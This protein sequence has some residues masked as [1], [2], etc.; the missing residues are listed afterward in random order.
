[1]H[2][3]L[4]LNNIPLIKKCIKDMRLYW[5]TED[6][7]QDYYDAGLLGL[8]NGAK[9]YNESKAKPSTYLYKC[10][11]TAISKE[12]QLS[13]YPKRIINKMYKVPLDK[14][15][16]IDTD[17]TYLDLLVDPDVNVE[18]EVLRNETIEEL[19][20][21]VNHLKPEKDKLFLYEYYGLLGYKALNS[22]ELAKKYNVSR[23]MVNT[24]LTRARKKIREY[25]EKRRKI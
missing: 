12:I 13:N 17:T 11:R 10:I 15:I 21:A 9:T 6:E 3:E 25:L 24:R 18:E 2:D 14:E 16:S 8:I 1:M 4:I 22:S 23:S 7:F 19:I 5:N 20:N